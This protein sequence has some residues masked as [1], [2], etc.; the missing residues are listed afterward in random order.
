MLQNSTQYLSIYFFRFIKRFFSLSK[1]KN[2]LSSY[3]TLSN[4]PP[5][6]KSK[7]PIFIFIFHIPHNFFIRTNLIVIFGFFFTLNTNNAPT[8]IQFCKYLVY[9]EV[10]YGTIHIISDMYAMQKMETKFPLLKNIIFI[11]TIK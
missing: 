2:I 7:T 6:G 11:C 5:L 9:W 8:E 4:K 1:R 3:L 10:Y